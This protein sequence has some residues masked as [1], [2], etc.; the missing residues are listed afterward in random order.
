MHAIEMERGM[1]I[2]IKEQL[3]FK[4]ISLTCDLWT[5]KNM[6]NS[7]IAVTAHTY[8]SISKD[9]MNLL[10]ALKVVNEKHSGENVKNNLIEILNTYDLTFDNISKVLTDN[11]SNTIKAFK[12][13][14]NDMKIIISLIK[15]MNLQFQLRVT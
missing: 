1:K 2:A 12:L 14:C 7:Y 15:L 11:A 13:L 6:T 3:N 8:N 4:S 9:F 5:C 10:L